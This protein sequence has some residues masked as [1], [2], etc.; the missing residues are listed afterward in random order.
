M[1]VC[2]EH[3]Y[4]V[5]I[6]T[7]M[8]INKWRNIAHVGSPSVKLCGLPSMMETLNRGWCFLGS[9]ITISAYWPASTWV[10]LS[11]WVLWVVWMAWSVWIPW[12]VVV[13][14]CMWLS[15]IRV[16]AAAS[17]CSHISSSLKCCSDVCLID[18][19]ADGIGIV[20]ESFAYAHF[21]CHCNCRLSTKLTLTFIYFRW[22]GLKWGS[23][24]CQ[25]KL[26]LHQPAQSSPPI[27]SPSSFL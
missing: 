12:L 1:I 8:N 6:V 15:S 3:H 7:E 14:A 11:V 22:S 4:I 20:G 18:S 25:E 19:A 26:W 21:W 10:T 13:H 23:S 16:K 2:S 27:L 24:T 17:V 5:A 9:P